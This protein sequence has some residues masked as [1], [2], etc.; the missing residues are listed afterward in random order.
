[1]QDNVD[2][3]HPK[4][5]LGELVGDRSVIYRTE[6]TPAN[7]YRCI[8]RVNGKQIGDAQTATCKQGATIRAA[9]Q[10]L[11]ILRGNPETSPIGT[12]IEETKKKAYQVV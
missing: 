11:R 6:S 8:V 2:I 9:E 3:M 1:M 4:N 12:C 10:A 5:R 7:N